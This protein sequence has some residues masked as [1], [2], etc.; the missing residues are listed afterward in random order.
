MM[1][2]L[3]SCIRQYRRDS[4]L[5]PLF[6]ILESVLE[7]YIPFQMANLIDFGVEAGD[8]DYILRIGAFLILLCLLSLCCGA[9]SG[10]FAASASAGF[11]HNLR[12]DIFAR[13]QAFSF[14]NIDRFSTSGIVTRLTTDVTNLQNAYQMVVRMAVRSPVMLVAALVAAARVSP[15]LSLVFLCV[16]PFLAGGLYLI[17]SRTHPIFERVFRTYDRLNL[18]VRENLHGVRVVKAF[19]REPYEI[20][21]FNN[22]SQSIYQDF[23]KAER[24]L[25]FNAPLMQLC[26]YCCILLLSW[27]GAKM[28]V[29][30]DLSTGNLMS[31]LTY[32]SQVLMSLMML[33]MIFVM[34]VMSRASAERIDEILSEPLDLADDAVGVDAV[35]NG[36]IEFENVSFGYHG[37]KGEPCLRNVSLHIP[38]GSTVGIVGATGSAKTTLVQLIP[39]LYDATEGRVLVAGRDV[40]EYHL[41]TLRNAVG[42]VLQKNLLFSGTVRENLR[43]GNENATDAQLDAACRQAQAEEFIRTLPG[44]YDYAVEQGGSNLSGGQRQRLCIAR[45][46][47]KRPAILILDDSTSAVDTHTESLIRQA[48]SAELPDTTKLIIAQRISSVQDADF[49]VVLEHGAIDAVGTHDQLLRENQIYQEIYASQQKGGEQDA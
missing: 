10:F 41:Q 46:L 31:L 39:R 2:R 20:E 44:G 34:T 18:V 1:K 11:A 14:T 6:V 7:V 13:V 38:G 35:P 40:R 37:K 19:A 49:I 22:V 26:M 47:L 21:K 3:F 15:R 27:F 5:A 42:M 9:L 8:L 16:A 32:A 30:G 36:D 45:A 43:W 4:L 29:V 24:R 25:A 23:S 48:F 12:Q 33:S 28:I 17:M